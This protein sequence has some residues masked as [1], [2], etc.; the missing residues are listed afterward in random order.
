MSPKAGESNLFRQ[1]D[2]YRVLR[3]LVA[4]PSS[5]SQ[6]VLPLLPDKLA[7][8]GVGQPCLAA[9]K[10]HNARRA[11]DDQ[12]GEQGQ[13]AEADKLSVAD[14][15]AVGVDGLLQGDL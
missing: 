6:Q 4:R 3:L 10:K 1:D 12:A 5:L 9:P 15:D 11:Q 13:Q 14:E 7:V 2:V 8:L